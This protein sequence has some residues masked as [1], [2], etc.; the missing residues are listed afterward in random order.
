[1]IH[2]PRT[3]QHQRSPSVLLATTFSLPSLSLP[4]ISPRCHSPACVSFRRVTERVYP[5]PYTSVVP[6]SST[7]PSSLLDT[8][9]VIVLTCKYSLAE[10]SKI[11]ERLDA[12]YILERCDSASASRTAFGSDILVQCGRERS[13]AKESIGGILISLSLTREREEPRFEHSIQISKINKVQ[14]NLLNYITVINEREC[15]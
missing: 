3:P 8:S 5:P 6:S 1:M 2:F 12:T 10:A 14:V 15:F 9:P 4:P 7:A 13:N 11:A